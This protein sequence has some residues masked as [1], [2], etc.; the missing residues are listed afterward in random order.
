MKCSLSRKSAERFTALGMPYRVGGRWANRPDVFAWRGR[1]KV[2]S[3][4][5]MK[6]STYNCEGWWL[7]EIVEAS[8]LFDLFGIWA[9]WTRGHGRVCNKMRDRVHGGRKTSL[10]RRV[11]VRF[12]NKIPYKCTQRNRWTDFSMKNK[13]HGKLPQ[14]WTV[15]TSRR[16]RGTR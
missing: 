16:N 2:P 5:Q 9:R 12:S 10:T 7:W 13:Q 1:G 6:R 8:N 11:V 14:P 4:V 3:F 15:K